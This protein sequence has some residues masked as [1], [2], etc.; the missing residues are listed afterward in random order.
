MINQHTQTHYHPRTRNKGTNT[1]YSWAVLIAQFRLSER[2]L[3]QKETFVKRVVL[4]HQGAQWS[5]VELDFIGDSCKV[6]RDHTYSLCTEQGAD[7]MEIGEVMQSS[8][9]TSLGELSPEPSEANELS[10]GEDSFEPPDNLLED[11]DYD[12]STDEEYS[13]DED[14][15][16]EDCS[17]SFD[18][19]R[20]STANE[21]MTP[22]VAGDCSL[23]SSKNAQSR[24]YE[25]MGQEDES[26]ERNNL[27]Q[28]LDVSN[29]KKKSEI[30]TEN[31][32]SDVVNPV[33]HAGEGGSTFVSTD[34]SNVKKQS[35][36]KTENVP[37]DVVSP[38]ISAGEGR[39]PIVSTD[40]SNVRKE[41]E[42]K[43]ENVPSDV[44]N[45]FISA[46]ECG[47]HIVSTEVVMKTEGNETCCT[48]A[49]N[50]NEGRGEMGCVNPIN[51]IVIH[52]PENAIKGED[53]D[54]PGGAQQLIPTGGESGPVSHSTGANPKEAF[55]DDPNMLPLEGYDE[56]EAEASTE[57]DTTTVESPI[58]ALP[59]GQQSGEEHMP[60]K[61]LGVMATPPSLAVCVD[62]PTNPPTH[63]RLRRGPHTNRSR[64]TPYT[65]WEDKMHQHQLAIRSQLTSIHSTLGEGLQG[66]S[67]QVVAAN[68]SLF[69]ELRELRT[70][71]MRTARRQ[72]RIQMR[73][74]AENIAAANR[75]ASVLEGYVAVM[76]TSSTRRFHPT[77][78][79]THGQQLQPIS[80]TPSP[81]ELST[82]RPTSL[83]SSAHRARK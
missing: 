47:S 67:S 13:N 39:S 8:P 36:I 65:T 55:E 20:D 79:D 66:L 16:T 74:H 14:T 61:E 50:I 2:E 28:S 38:L 76:T 23:Y 73:Q 6:F 43:T 29:C 26:S 11:P 22:M 81:L 71:Q 68:E 58:L 15:T 31:L 59:V 77:A 75:V 1:D 35:E 51:E 18:V 12:P 42:I 62:V 63:P 57:Q 40:L 41:S 5:E 30:E 7:V 70:N 60:V 37:S 44:V 21:N 72:Q 45:P 4:K 27:P 24:D 80:E 78:S 19:Q 69:G 3:A 17:T 32:T 56:E 52:R 46:G 33:I 34:L 64:P 48:E 53:E 54:D 10:D 9:A 49:Q 82:P 83:T 25:K